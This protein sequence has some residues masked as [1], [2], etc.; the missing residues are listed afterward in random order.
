MS[1]SLFIAT[2]DLTKVY[3]KTAVVN[4][5]NLEI[6]E[7]QITAFLG[8]NGA[9][10][11]TTIKMLLGITHPTSGT[12]TVLGI[13]IDDS[14]RSCDIRRDVAYVAEDKNLYAYMNVGQLISFSRSFYPKWRGEIEKRLL[15]QFELPLSKK[16][17]ALS[18][19]MRGKLAL[20]VAL[21]RR[22]TLLIL[23]EP[24]EGLDP[25]GIEE[26][27]Q[28]LASAAAEGVTIFFSSH[29]ISEV[30]RIAD[31]ACIIDHGELRMNIS[32]D[33]LRSEYRR[34]T[35]AFHGDPPE[36]AFQLPG[37]QHLQTVGRQAVLLAHKNAETVIERAHA[38]GAAQVEVDPVSL[39]ELFLQTVKDDKNALV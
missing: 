19:G 33:D 11:S 24:S 25:V 2:H 9:G 18:K 17:R 35:I 39:R 15:K 38:E 31:R 20:L 26:L 7:H 8:R 3:G 32:M 16:V 5:L 28:E 29:Q 10:K 4:R 27:L 22:P 23:D 6:P 37:V 21:A 13:P 14:N 36:G 30:E 34:I 1:D 12:G